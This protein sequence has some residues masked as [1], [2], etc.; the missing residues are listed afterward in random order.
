[1]TRTIKISYKHVCSII[2]ST[3]I[4]KQNLVLTLINFKKI[5]VCHANKNKGGKRLLAYQKMEIVA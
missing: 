3:A 4:S 1:M 2:T 5:I